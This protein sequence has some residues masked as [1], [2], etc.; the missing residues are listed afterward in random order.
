MT[1]NNPKSNNNNTDNKSSI[2]AMLC[3]DPNGQAI[4]FKGQIDPNQSGTYTSMMRLASQLD[5]FSTS[6]SSSTLPSST[7]SGGSGAGVANAGDD[8]TK[9]T[10]KNTMSGGTTATSTSSDGMD[11]VVNNNTSNNEGNK[12]MDD[13]TKNSS[14][15]TTN[16]NNNNSKTSSKPSIAIETDQYITLI[17]SYYGDHT[18]VT[19][20]P[21]SKLDRN[22]LNGVVAG[23]S[24]NVSG[25]DSSNENNTNENKNG[26]DGIINNTNNSGV[27]STIE[28]DGNLDDKMDGNENI[29]T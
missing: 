27:A 29:Q 17:K 6:N 7:S 21:N 25:G 26:E 15:P 3:C 13:T 10:S 19:K 22:S 11:V 2:N 12:I 1:P 14:N 20:L 28:E 8:T 24:S 16:N 4:G 23:E 18:V 9:N 5:A